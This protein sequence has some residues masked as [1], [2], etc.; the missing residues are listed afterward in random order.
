MKP[1]LAIWG[2]EERIWEEVEIESPLEVEKGLFS[3]SVAWAK[4]KCFF[5]LVE[6]WAEKQSDVY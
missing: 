5:F 6:N 4:G 1:Y 2:W 3:L